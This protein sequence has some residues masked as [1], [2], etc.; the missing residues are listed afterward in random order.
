MISRR[1]RWTRQTC[2]GQWPG[3]STT[4]QSPSLDSILTPFDE[5]AVGWIGPEHAVGLL[6]DV[7][8]ELRS[9]CSGTPSWRDRA[10]AGGGDSLGLARGVVEMTGV[11]M[12]PELRSASLDHPRREPHVIG[13]GVGT[14]E[15]ADVLDRE[16]GQAERGLE[17]SSVGLVTGR[18]TVDEHDA[19]VALDRVGV[20]VGDV[21]PRQGKAEAPQPG[22]DVERTGQ[23]R[24]D[25]PALGGRSN[26]G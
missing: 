10:L 18:A 4:S 3:V 6:A 26:H 19:V 12:H 22:R 17:R 13:V 7:A 23:V 11:R 14:D 21:V 24:L 20:D 2:V 25:G 8:V 16:P 5:Q 1:S 9:R 15:H